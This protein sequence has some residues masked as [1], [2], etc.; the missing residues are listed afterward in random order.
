MKRLFLF[1]SILFFAFQAKSAHLIGGEIYYECLGNNTWVVGITM[2]RDCYTLP[3]EGATQFDSLL[4]VS[5]YQKSNN[6][7]LQLLQ[8]PQFSTERELPLVLNSLCLT[9]TPDV[10]VAEMIYRDTFVLAIPMG[11][12]YLVNQRCCRTP[13]ALNLLPPS[14]QFGSTYYTF[15]PDSS[16]ADCNTSPKF[17]KVPPKI[18]C[19]GVDL[20]IDY[21]ATDIDGDSLVYR[22]CTP[23]TGGGKANGQGLDSPIPSI[24]ASPP[25]TSIVWS[26]GFSETNQIPSFPAMQ[27]NEDSGTITARPN[28][29]GTYVTGVCVD[30]YRNG[31]KISESRRDFQQSTTFCNIQASAALD[32]AIEECIG[33]EIEFFNQSSLGFSFLWDFGELN[34]QTDSSTDQNPI[35]NYSDTGIYTIRLIAF[36]QVCNDTTFYDY[37]VRPKLLPDFTPLK[38][39]CFDRQNFNLTPAGVFDSTSIKYWDFEFASGFDEDST[40]QHITNLVFAEPGEQLIRLTYEDFGCVKTKEQILDIWANPA[41]E[42]I[43]LDPYYCAPFKGSLNVETLNAS[44]PS[45]QWYLDSNFISQ[46]DSVEFV[47]FDPGEYNLSIRLITDSLCKDTFDLIKQN[48]ILV[49][50]TPI[51]QFV[52]KDLELNMF[53]NN[54]NPIFE[55][56]DASVNALNLRYYL[57]DSLFTRERSFNLSVSDTGDYSIC[58]IAIHENGCRDTS[59]QMI[60]LK[61]E[62]LIYIPNSFSP[63]NDGTND[64]WLPKIYVEDYYF[65]EIYNRWGEV[66]FSSEDSTLGW[67]GKKNNDKELCQIGVYGYKLSVKDNQG[68]FWTYDGTVSLIR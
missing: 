1:I 56:T 2:Y 14:D 33:L 42:L 19:A 4:N 3:E 39:S 59:Y 65:L 11:G 23:I 12:V 25:F 24:P 54:E 43:G 18:L 31:I 66:I 29:V 64:F 34:I 57:Q 68:L 30:E 28:Q 20:E 63:N 46:A 58:Q 10:C 37:Y 50:D 16:V 5:I 52:L 15:I 27:I 62:Y 51:A 7:L 17:N 44:K 22:W 67:N 8:I 21:S 6:Q 55:G 36:G 53:D 61:P 47:I 41:M 35:W 38:S 40:N 32:S 48:A 45:F 9:D 13:D 49:K 60:R 26:S